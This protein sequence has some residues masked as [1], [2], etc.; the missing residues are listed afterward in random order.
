MSSRIANSFQRWLLTSTLA[1]S[2]VIGGTVLGEAGPLRFPFG[3]GS[4]SQQKPQQQSQKQQGQPVDRLKAT[5]FTQQNQDE[6]DVDDPTEDIQTRLAKNARNVRLNFME[7]SWKTV[8]NSYAK[9]IGKKLIAE[10]R[11]IP[12][13]RF[14]RTD[15][16]NYTAAEALK[17]LNK[18]L[19]SYDC[20]LV[21]K[22]NQ[23]VL[24]DLTATHPNYPRPTIDSQGIVTA[25]ALP[26]EGEK[27]AIGF[28]TSQRLNVIQ[29]SDAREVP[30]STDPVYRRSNNPIRQVAAVSESTLARDASEDPL[31]SVP[32]R[33]RRAKEIANQL[34]RAFQKQCEVVNEGPDGLP[35]I[36]VLEPA[37]AAHE[38]TNTRGRIVLA[39]PR[40]LARF[41]IALDAD[42]NQMSIQAS[43][44]TARLVASMIRKL[45]VQEF[46]DSAVQLFASEHGTEVEN[47][48]ELV[49]TQLDKLERARNRPPLNR[50]VAFQGDDLPPAADPDQPE[51]TPRAKGRSSRVQVDP[52]Q[53]ATRQPRIPG[54]AKPGD[55]KAG[56]LDLGTLRGDV[57][58]ETL[59]DLGVM[60]LTGNE[61][62][63]ERVKAIIQE[64][65]KLSAG[66]TPDVHLLLLKNTNS[67]ALAELLS[68]VYERL[69]GRR[70]PGGAAGPATGGPAA[71]AGTVNQS[72]TIIPVVKPNAILIVAS[73]TDI[74]SVLKLA[75]EL[76]QPVDP[77]AEFKM[78]R[79][80][81][82]VASQVLLTIQ[83]FYEGRVGLG[84]RV[85]AVADVRTNSV[86]VHARPRDV[87]EVAALIK[88]LDQS[89]P[90]SVSQMKVFQLRN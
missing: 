38:A 85:L 1:S 73:A 24:M 47:M 51:E 75:E 26:G 90:A 19:Q 36:R 70:R 25:H 35:A 22:S 63:V 30:I 11:L 6:T 54:T 4:D 87:E 76:D 72:V 82:A 46:S 80:K 83:T 21:E 48:A 9:Q 8:L 79:L 69:N 52:D 60:I 10:P 28:G 20:K 2:L 18:E 57:R 34:Y 50:A 68:Q 65:E 40:R 42:R 53:P 58:I 84:S 61:K 89:D 41:T 64:I 74:E 13:A 7:A 49:R 15:R 29:A 56:G 71:P 16:S 5:G 45:D 59:P 55:P 3:S 62:D 33:H 81:T 43:P 88:E 23:L 67:E 66:A 27:N 14:T 32:L 86:L 78:F 37:Q 12:S 77:T 31:L 44:A 17:V 39:A